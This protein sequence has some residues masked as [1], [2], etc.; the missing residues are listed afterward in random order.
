MR[1]FLRASPRRTYDKFFASRSPVSVVQF[2]GL[3]IL[4]GNLIAAGL[5]L[6]ALFLLKISKESLDAFGMIMFLIP[7][8]ICGAIIWLGI[9][10]IR[11]AFAGRHSHMK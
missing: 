4:G 9:L 7:T 10:H 1:Y 3:M 11:R 5:G 6:L 2:W 8:G